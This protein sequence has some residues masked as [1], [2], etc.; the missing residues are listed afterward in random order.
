MI[1]LSAHH[2][3]EIAPFPPLR[4]YVS[5]KGCVPSWNTAEFAA[6]CARHGCV[7]TFTYILPHTRY[8]TGALGFLAR[9]NAWNMVEKM[10][11]SDFPLDHW[12]TAAHYAGQ[13]GHEE[14]VDNILAHRP[15]LEHLSL[16]QAALTGACHKDRSALVTRWTPHIDRQ[17]ILNHLGTIAA[18]HGAVNCIEILRERLSPS[19]WLG[20]LS[21]CVD[22]NSNQP[23]VADLLIQHVPPSV[24]VSKQWCV[25]TV[26]RLGLAPSNDNTAVWRFVLRHLS[27]SEV[28]A[29]LPKQSAEQRQKILNAHQHALL[30]SEIARTADHL[31][32][33]KRKI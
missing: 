4:E 22:L 16:I 10:G 23:I 33:M 18:Q 8:A 15:A 27:P 1:P 11:V 2:L 5:E 12:K 28:F 25:K 21:A 31:S 24:A 29:I 14:F 3:N 6:L 20:A 9:I 7:E 19:G 30:T 17:D 26:R 32:P 13:S